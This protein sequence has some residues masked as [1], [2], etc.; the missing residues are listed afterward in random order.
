MVRFLGVMPKRRCIIRMLS[1]IWGRKEPKMLR[2]ERLL[3]HVA[4]KLNH[5]TTVGGAHFS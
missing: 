5:G 1:R 2:V 3:E 4:K